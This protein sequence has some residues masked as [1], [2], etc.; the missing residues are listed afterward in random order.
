MVD[1]HDAPV[2]D[3]RDVT[4]LAD[5][6]VILDAITWRIDPGQHWAIL[7]PNGAGKT[8]LL[9]L[10]CGYLWPN[11][12]GTI[13][14]NGEDLLDL[15]ELRRGI[16]WVTS[17]L[18]LQI[19]RCEQVLHTVLSGALAQ[20]GYIEWEPPTD[21]DLAHARLCLDQLG[22]LH[23]ADRRFGTLSQGEQQKVLIARARMNKPMLVI[24]DEPC[25]GMDPGARERFLASI[26]RLATTDCTLSLV[27]VTHHIEEIMPAFSQTLVLKDGRIVRQGATA[28]VLQSAVLQEIYGVPMHIRECQGRYWPMCK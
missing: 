9:N 5:D 25:A 1:V 15:R 6:R 22:C 20:V 11:G 2:L 17:S 12:G 19:P 3:L 27:F 14:R 18:A 8:T 16:G 4:W 23:L 28:D 21:H 10:A 26:Q 13:L 7:G 24:L